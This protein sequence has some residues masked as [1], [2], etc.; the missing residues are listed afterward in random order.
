MRRSLKSYPTIGGWVGDIV[1]DN[2][3]A[4]DVHEGGIRKLGVEV[5]CHGL[6]GRIEV[7]GQLLQRLDARSALAFPF[8]K[9]RRYAAQGSQR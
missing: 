1:H 9:L 6:Q 7:D 4:V 3:E 2:A 5:L 8:V